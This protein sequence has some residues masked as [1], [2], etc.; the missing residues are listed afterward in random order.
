MLLLLL[1]LL[2]MLM[3][4]PPL[5]SDLFANTLLEVWCAAGMDMSG[6]KVV[7]KWASDEITSHA[8]T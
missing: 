2:L 6:G 1:L 7:F 3:L 5:P 8:A 4:L